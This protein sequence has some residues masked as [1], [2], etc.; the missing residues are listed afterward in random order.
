MEKRIGSLNEVQMGYLGCTWEPTP[1]FYYLEVSLRQLFVASLIVSEISAISLFSFQLMF[2]TPPL[3]L[4]HNLR[5]LKENSRRILASS[6]TSG[7]LN[8]SVRPGSIGL[9][10]SLKPRTPVLWSRE[11]RERRSEVLTFKEYDHRR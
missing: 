6:T 7:Y 5:M 2:L 11:V 8:Q 4:K 10:T 9:L 3:T 1:W